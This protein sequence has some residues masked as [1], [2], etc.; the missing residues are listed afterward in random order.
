[1][2]SHTKHVHTPQTLCLVHLELSPVREQE[3]QEHADGRKVATTAETL[4]SDQYQEDIE[5]STTAQ[6]KYQ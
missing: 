2:P 6:R 1:M 4:H 3:Y 5:A